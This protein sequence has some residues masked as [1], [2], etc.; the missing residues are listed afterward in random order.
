MIAPR[1]GDEIHPVLRSVAA[2]GLIPQQTFATWTWN[3]NLDHDPYRHW[4]LLVGE[5]REAAFLRFC[6]RFRTRKGHQ[7]PP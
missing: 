1:E 6:S 7:S 5:H 3:P 2:V 4:D